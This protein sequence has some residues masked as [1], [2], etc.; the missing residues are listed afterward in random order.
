[1]K[2]AILSLASLVLC[3]AVIIPL[4]ALPASDISGIWTGKAGMNDGG[5][6]P[7]TVTLKKDG[8]KYAGTIVDEMGLMPEGTALKDVSLQGNN[9]KLSFQA[10]ENTTIMIIKV[11]LTING[12]TMT[13]RW[14]DEEHGSGGSVELA[15]KK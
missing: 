9:L 6:D 14:E 3:L 7:L 15:R 10:K 1:M 2:K 13:G 5:T 12:E 8:K 11:S 4:A